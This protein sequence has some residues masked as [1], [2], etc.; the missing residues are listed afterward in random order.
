ME[1]KEYTREDCRRELN[2]R[3]KVQTKK[4]PATPAKLVL[5]A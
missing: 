3:A 2:K 1:A 4:K 5:V